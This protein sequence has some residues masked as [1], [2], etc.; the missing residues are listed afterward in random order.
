MSR[1]WVVPQLTDRTEMPVVLHTKRGVARELLTA[2]PVGEDDVGVHSRHIQ[3]VDQGHLLPGYK[4]H[5]ST[6]GSGDT[7]ARGFGLNVRIRMQLFGSPGEAGGMY[8]RDPKPDV[9]GERGGRSILLKDGVQTLCGPVCMRGRFCC[10]LTAVWHDPACAH[11]PHLPVGCVSERLQLLNDGGTHLT[12]KIRSDQVRPDRGRSEQ[13]E[14][15][16]AR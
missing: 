9:P 1:G 14:T 10:F 8:D 12:D 13:N 7:A 15:D 6:M 5:G 11:G 16:G 2:Q 4:V 3:M